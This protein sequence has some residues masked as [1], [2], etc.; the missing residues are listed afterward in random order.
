MRNGK[1]THKFADG[2]FYGGEWKDN[3]K[4]G[5]GNRIWSDG[6]SYKGDCKEDALHGKG[7]MTFSNQDINNG[8]WKRGLQD[9]KGTMKYHHNGDVYSGE[10]RN[11]KIHGQGTM[12]LE[13]A[14]GDIWKST[15]EWTKEGIKCGIFRELPWPKQVCYDNGE[16]KLNI[17]VKH[18]ATYDGDNK[19]Y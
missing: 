9:G 17:K 12:E 2:G 11:S 1:G 15:G 5:E 14:A 19:Q 18:E 3:K 16:V 13:Y 10:F 8:E 4:D 7:V 6:T